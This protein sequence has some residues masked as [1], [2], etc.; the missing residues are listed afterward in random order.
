MKT[1]RASRVQA[2]KQQQQ[3]QQQ[4]PKMFYISL[5]LSGVVAFI[6]SYI[7][8]IWYFKN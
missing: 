1:K 2:L 4:Q 5:S 6:F 7:L 8:L 3:Q